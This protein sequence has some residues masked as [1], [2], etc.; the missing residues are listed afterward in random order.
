M[1]RST[2]FG[3]GVE[4]ALHCLMYLVDA[5]EGTNLGIKEIAAFQGVSETYLSKIFA[6]LK[7]A[8][9]V[10]STPG[11][12]GGYELSRPT[13]QITFLNVVEAVEGPISLFQCRNI[14]FNCV[15]DQGRPLPPSAAQ[16]TCVIH[17]VMLE[18]EAHVRRHLQSRTLGWLHETL[19]EILPA[20]RQEATKRWFQQALGP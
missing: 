15:L 2:S 13:G 19:R 5:P 7:K 11:V 3:V 9:L 6:R 4:Y 12:R 18:A 8:G 10:R 17:S 14:R 16:G 1:N 20:E